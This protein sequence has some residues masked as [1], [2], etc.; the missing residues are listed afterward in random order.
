MWEGGSWG[1]EDTEMGSGEGSETGSEEFANMD[2][3]YVELEKLMEEAG[4]LRRTG[5]GLEGR[6]GRRREG[7]GRSRQH[8][9]NRV[10]VGYRRARL[11][12]G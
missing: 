2:E 11:S 1:R 9:R 6:Q 8:S 7:G 5:A 10:G 4:E 3:A 12:R